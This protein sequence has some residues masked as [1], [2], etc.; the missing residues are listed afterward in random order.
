MVTIPISCSQ[1]V[2]PSAV[3]NSKKFF[4]NEEWKSSPR[5]SLMNI[6]GLQGREA[7]TGPHTGVHT[8]GRATPSPLPHLKAPPPFRWQSSKG[9]REAQT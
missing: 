2:G 5:D 9:L 1:D 8:A 7:V 6:D 3:I 4:A